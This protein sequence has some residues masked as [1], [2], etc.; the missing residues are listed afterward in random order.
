MTLILFKQA[1]GEPFRPFRLF[2]FFS[3]FTLLC[4]HSILLISKHAKS[5]E[6]QTLKINSMYLIMQEL[7]PTQLHLL[8]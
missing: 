3:L 7:K 6:A 4:L 2:F 1:L 5:F 8:N